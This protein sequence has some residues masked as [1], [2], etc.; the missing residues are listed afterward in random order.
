MRKKQQR[1]ISEEPFEKNKKTSP[2]AGNFMVASPVF[3]R[4]NYQIWFVK[5]KSYLEASGLWNVVMSKIQ[6]L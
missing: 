2:I 1:E 5:M 4:E 3:S 6:P